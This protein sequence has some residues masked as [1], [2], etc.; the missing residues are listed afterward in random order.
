[1]TVRAAQAPDPDQAAAA[2][3]EQ[4]KEEL[5]QKLL[6]NPEDV[7]EFTVSEIC[8]TD[9]ETAKGIPGA[10]CTWYPDE[11]PSSN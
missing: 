1:M 9:E 10:G 5:R 3:L 6:N 11:Y 2:A 4:L 7:P 8:E